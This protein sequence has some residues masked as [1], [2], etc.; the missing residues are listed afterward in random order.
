MARGERMRADLLLLAVVVVAVGFDDVV[1]TP[2]ADRSTSVR[3]AQTGPLPTSIVNP[4]LGDPVPPGGH[5]GATRRDAP[6]VVPGNGTAVAPNGALVPN[7]VGNG[8]AP[9]DPGGR[10]G[11]MNEGHVS[12]PSAGAV[13]NAA[14]GVAP[15]PGSAVGEAVV[16]PMGR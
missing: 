6:D 11:P 12:A 14:T 8:I 10:L 4:R 13:P 7:A 16:P 5:L 2:S 1:A 15:A 9:T 3:L